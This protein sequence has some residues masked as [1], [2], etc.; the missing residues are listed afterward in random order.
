MFAF[1]DEPAAEA[2]LRL[3][4]PWYLDT[5]RS[6]KD[7]NILK[8][9]AIRPFIMHAFGGMYLDMDV[10][11]Y[12]CDLVRSVCVAATWCARCQR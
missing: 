7:S 9:D 6:Y 10:E 1:W 4:Y 8:S 11:C 12:R 2:L 3:R 5:W